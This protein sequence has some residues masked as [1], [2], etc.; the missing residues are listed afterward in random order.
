MKAV[1]FDLDDTLYDQIQPFRYAY[2]HLFPGLDVDV[3]KL[4]NLNRHYA[5]ITYE[6]YLAGQLTNEQNQIERIRRALAD[7][8]VRAEETRCL[9]FQ[10]VYSHQQKLIEMSGIM[11]DLLDMCVKHVLTG[12]LSNGP[13]E[14]QRTKVKTL[15]I[16][17]YLNEKDIYVS[18]DFNVKKPDP[19]I[20]D[21]VRSYT[22]Y[23][24]K[25]C[26]YVGD[27]YENDIIGAHKA[28]WKSVWLNRRHNPLPADNVAD[29][30]VNSEEE[31]YQLLMQ[32][33]PD[34]SLFTE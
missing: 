21:L 18:G 22:P 6:E 9:E 29:H 4:F 27:H 12:I 26:Y 2:E 14:H 25:D 30:V 20:F 31:L 7:F 10:V 34:D 33:L 1:F 13:S 3:E 16:Y 32:L 15:G 23:E 19:A 28:G 5:N 11:H 17:E 8:G 24:A